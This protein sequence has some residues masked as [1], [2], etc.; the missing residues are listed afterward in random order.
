MEVEVRNKCCDLHFRVSTSVLWIA[1]INKTKPIFSTGKGWKSKEIRVVP[2]FIR[3]LIKI[4]YLIAL[5]NYSSIEMSSHIFVFDFFDLDNPLGTISLM[6]ILIFYFLEKWMLTWVSGTYKP[7]ASRLSF[8]RSN[9][10]NF[11]IF[12]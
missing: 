5:K 4:F 12:I 1:F 7:S 3:F 8:V 10:A 11:K 6:L 2:F 9:T